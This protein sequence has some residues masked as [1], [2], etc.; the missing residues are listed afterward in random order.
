M[1]N[2]SMDEAAGESSHALSSLMEKGTEMSRKYLEVS[3]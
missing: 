1:T 3:S 2:T